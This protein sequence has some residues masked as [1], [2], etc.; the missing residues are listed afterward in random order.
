MNAPTGTMAALLAVKTPQALISVPAR[1]DTLSYQTGRHAKVYY[2]VYNTLYCF[3]NDFNN[4][5]KKMSFTK[6]V[7]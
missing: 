5:T 6:C 2:K 3:F 1:K 7:K 4:N